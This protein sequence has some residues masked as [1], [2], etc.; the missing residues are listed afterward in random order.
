M[1]DRPPP[2]VFSRY[3]ACSLLSNFHKNIELHG[4][5]SYKNQTQVHEMSIDP[6][7]PQIAFWALY[8]NFIIQYEYVYI[9]SIEVVTN[10]L[11]IWYIHLCNSLNKFGVQ[12]NQ[13]TLTSKTLV[14]GAPMSS[15]WKY[16]PS[17]PFN[18]VEL[19]L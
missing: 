10:L 16:F 5:P 1:R 7:V 18:M 13:I 17:L 12:K 15:F 14:F 19:Y 6:I 11:Q 4:W 2:N 8:Q 9:F 3:C